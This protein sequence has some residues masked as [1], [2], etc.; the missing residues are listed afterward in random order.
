MAGQAS[1]NFGSGCSAAPSKR[2]EGGH[3]PESS[4][5]REIQRVL[6]RAIAVSEVIAVSECLIF[7]I[8]QHDPQG[9]PLVDNVFVPALKYLISKRDAR[10]IRVAWYLPEGEKFFHELPAEYADLVLENLLALNRIDD[11]AESILTPIAM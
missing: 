9:L 10:W 2:S 4:K 1:I 7:A 6:D 3:L 5:V 8:E 11:D